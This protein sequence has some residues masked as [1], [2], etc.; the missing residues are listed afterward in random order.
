VAA[1]RE[2]RAAGFDHLSV[3]LIY[4]HPAETDAD[5]RASLDAALEAEPDHV[6]AYALTVEPGTR[7]Q[8]DVRR[9]RVAAPDEDALA[10]RYELADELLGGAG[11]PWYEVS[12]WAAD[13]GAR[14]RHNEGYWAGGDWW[15]VGPGAHSHVAGERWSNVRHPATWAARL[16]EGRS[17]A[18]E[19]EQLTPAQRR[20]ERILLEVRRVEGLDL[21]SARVD[22]GRAGELAASGLLDPDALASGR[23][24]LTLRGRQLSD[25]VTRALC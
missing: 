11:L 23:A 9:G 10:R 14:C 8:A 15:G 16:A 2:V 20:L 18:A 12:S 19:R 21:A 17:P 5:W 7:L 1:A 4:G 13:E 3:D 25:F 6:S 24:V 22:A